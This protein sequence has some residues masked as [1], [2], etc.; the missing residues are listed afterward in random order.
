MKPDNS[1]SNSKKKEEELNK[2]LERI[3][4]ELKKGDDASIKALYELKEL[5][6][7]IETYK[8]AG[9]ITPRLVS[10]VWILK[11]FIHDLWANLGDDSK[12]LPKT[13]G[14]QLLKEIAMSLGIFIQNSLY[15]N[16]PAESIGTFENVV[17]FY[18]ELLHLTE[19]ASKKDLSQEEYIVL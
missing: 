18:Y 10:I 15:R 9:K 5:L 3:S 11:T 12:G 17:K 4:L 14:A 13:N 7:P 6:Y 16:R 2:Q 1:T 19:E 8:L